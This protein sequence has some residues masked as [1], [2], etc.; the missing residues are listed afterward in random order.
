M[1]FGLFKKIV[2]LFNVGYLT[3]KGWLS[4]WRNIK[5]VTLVIFR[6]S[7]GVL[8]VDIKYQLRG[9]VEER[10]DHKKGLEI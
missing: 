7:E 3:E 1:G 9:L 10:T 2:Y 8:S 5:I 6:T 4:P